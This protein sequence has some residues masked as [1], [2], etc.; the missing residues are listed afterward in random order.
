MFFVVHLVF[1]GCW[2]TVGGGTMLDV[3]D[4]VLGTWMDGIEMLPCS[5]RKILFVI[6]VYMYDTIA[7]GP[8]FQTLFPL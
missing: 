1:V 5:A 7:R 4:G 3:L 8:C 6:L 2:R